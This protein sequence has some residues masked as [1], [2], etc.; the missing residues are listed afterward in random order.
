MNRDLIAIGASAGGIEALKQLAADL[1]ADLPAAVL[2]VV[3]MAPNGEFYLPQILD[4][5]GP[6]EVVAAEEGM[7]IERGRMILARPGFHLLVRDGHVHLGT[8]PRENRSKPAIDP[9]FRSVAAT[10]GGRAIGIVLSGWLNDGTS[11]VYA[12]KRCGGLA[13]AQD[14]TDALAPEMPRSAIIH[15]GVDY[16]ARIDAMGELLSQLTRQPAGPDMP[17]PPEVK[18]EAD[19]ALHGGQSIAQTANL[20]ERSVIA[21]AECGGGLTEIHDGNMLRFRCHTGH[22]FTA[23]TLIADQSEAVER[24]LLSALKTLEERAA[25]WTRMADRNEDSGNRR[26]ALRMKEKADI[27]KTEAE[28][29]RTLLESRREHAGVDDAVSASYAAL[30]D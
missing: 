2:V 28:L 12:I 19:I 29:I 30:G 11:G 7:K 20:G 16:T 15:A 13:V 23:E 25:M 27:S 9:L 14:P 18:V 24:A 6:L 5:V 8:G 1:P 3:H 17:V 4:R 22:A 21:C 10:Y 26:S